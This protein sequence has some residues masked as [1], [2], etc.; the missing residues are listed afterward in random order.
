[1]ALEKLE[2]ELQQDA[3]SQVSSLHKERPFKNSTKNTGSNFLFVSLFSYCVVHFRTVLTLI[4]DTVHAFV[5][6][7]TFIFFSKIPS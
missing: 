7:D 2:T 1:M 5:V 6:N 4:T 3:G